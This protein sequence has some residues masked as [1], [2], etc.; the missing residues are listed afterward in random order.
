MPA[1][2][3][4]SGD[5]SVGPR[6]LTRSVHGRWSCEAIRREPVSGREDVSH[7]DS[8]NLHSKCHR[9]PAH[10]P[11]VGVVRPPV[12][13]VW[14]AGCGLCPSVNIAG[15]SLVTAPPHQ[16]CSVTDRARPPTTHGGDAHVDMSAR[17]GDTPACAIAQ[18]IRSGAGSV[19]AIGRPL[20]SQSS[21]G[22]TRQ[23]RI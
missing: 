21:G 6:S 23:G 20:R 7:N 13:R 9:P 3:R 10:G 2:A 15:W 11:R 22:T 19:G 1:P 14:P 8:P 17:F 5:A 16:R 18:R 4:R 12:R